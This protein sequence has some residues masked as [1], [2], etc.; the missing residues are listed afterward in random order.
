LYTIAS[1]LIVQIILY[2]IESIHQVVELSLLFDEDRDENRR[3]N[4]QWLVNGARIGMQ[5]CVL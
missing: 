1:S 5:L 3:L 4:E 2:V